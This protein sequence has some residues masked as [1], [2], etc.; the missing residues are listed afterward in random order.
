MVSTGEDSDRTK[1]SKGPNIK[2]TK[3]QSKPAHLWPVTRTSSKESGPW[4]CQLCSAGPFMTASGTRRHYRNHYKKWDSV[5]DECFDMSENEKD[6][7]KLTKSL[8]NTIQMFPSATL[9]G[10]Q[11]V[12]PKQNKKRT[13]W[14][15]RDP[16]AALGR[17]PRSES[18]E[19]LSEV[20]DLEDQWRTYQTDDML[21]TDTRTVILDRDESDSPGPTVRRSTRPTKPV[22]GHRDPD[23]RKIIESPL[24]IKNSTLAS[25]IVKVLNTMT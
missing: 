21:T 18:Q 6:Q 14:Q 12:L 7:V 17:P 19:S 15:K 5:T 11:P 3:K 23:R 25:E 16:P 9:T 10:A 13:S 1:K 22:G 20:P 4:T 24:K 8:K 2:Y